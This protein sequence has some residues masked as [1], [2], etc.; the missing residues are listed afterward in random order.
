MSPGVRATDRR[1]VTHIFIK[2][3]FTFAPLKRP[4]KIS[5]RISISIRSKQTITGVTY[6]GPNPQ[7]SCPLRAA[8]HLLSL[9][10]LEVDSDRKQEWND[11]Q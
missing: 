1:E 6:L 7:V 2:E 10:N 4:Q 3:S 8:V 11:L 9:P 5:R